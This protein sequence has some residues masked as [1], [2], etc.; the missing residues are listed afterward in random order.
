[1]VKVE[2]GQIGRWLGCWMIGRL[3]NQ[4]YSSYNMY[5]LLMGDVSVSVMLTFILCVAY[6]IRTAF[7]NLTC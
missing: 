4:V 3:P 2:G 1:M 6:N 5:G 7:S